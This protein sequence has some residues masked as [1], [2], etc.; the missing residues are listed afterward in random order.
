LKNVLF[1]FL[2]WAA[3]LMYFSRREKDQIDSGYAILNFDATEKERGPEG[4][5]I[6]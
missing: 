5:L 3:G 2:H 6:S 4:P 1:D